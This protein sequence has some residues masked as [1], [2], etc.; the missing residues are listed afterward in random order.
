MKAYVGDDEIEVPAC[1][2]GATNWQRIVNYT[3]GVDFYGIVDGSWLLEERTV[4]NDDV[5]YSCFG[6]NAFADPATS[7]KLEEI[8]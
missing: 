2:C 1:A 3:G 5:V 7:A 8:N 4:D 6:C